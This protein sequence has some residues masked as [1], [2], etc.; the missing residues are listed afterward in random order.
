[1]CGHVCGF[2]YAEIFNGYVKGSVRNLAKLRTKP[3]GLK[4]SPRDT[5]FYNLLHAKNFHLPTASTLPH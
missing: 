2:T 5:C 1:M 4:F 3:K